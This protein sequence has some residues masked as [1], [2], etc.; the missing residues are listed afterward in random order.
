MTALS[1]AV[2]E[3]QVRR[4]G[5]G[6]KQ[7]TPVSWWEFGV[8]E[9]GEFLVLAF[10]SRTGVEAAFQVRRGVAATM[11]DALKGILGQQTPPPPDAA[12]H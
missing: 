6:E 5:S 8:D 9:S 4:G 11:I 3:A 1:P 7:V 12:R 2:A 10:R